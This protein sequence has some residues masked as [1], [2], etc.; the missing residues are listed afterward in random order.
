MYNFNIIF[1]LKKEVQIVTVFNPLDIT[2]LMTLFH[3]IS[4]REFVL[5]YCKKTVFISLQHKINSCIRVYLISF[6]GPKNRTQNVFATL[7]LRVCRSTEFNS[8]LCSC[9]SPKCSRQ[10]RRFFQHNRK[11]LHIHA[12]THTHTCMRTEQPPCVLAFRKKNQRFFLLF[13]KRRKLVGVFE[14]Q[15]KIIQ[16]RFE[17][18]KL[19]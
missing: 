11:F 2:N 6:D 15:N 5:L 4:M 9:I 19:G 14:R 3:A 8:S 13:L 18:K 10:K 17:R 12:Y 7:S 1:F 16:F